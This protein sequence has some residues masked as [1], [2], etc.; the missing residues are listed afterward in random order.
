MVVS[1]PLL[2]Q[3]FRD[4]SWKRVGEERVEW[5]AL[6]GSLEEVDLFTFDACVHRCSLVV[7]RL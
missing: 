4:V 1:V 5:V 7:V 6:I 3:W 2:C